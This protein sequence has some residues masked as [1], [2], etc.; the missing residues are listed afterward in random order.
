MIRKIG[1]PKNIFN[2]Q[3]GRMM[4]TK[5][6]VKGKLVLVIEMP[7]NV[8]SSVIRVPMNDTKTIVRIGIFHNR[9]RRNMANNTANKYPLI[10]E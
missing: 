4:L 9:D 6:C 2:A 1:I 7:R 5:L 8:S 3:L 10:T